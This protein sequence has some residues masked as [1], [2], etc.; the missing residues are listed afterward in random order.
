MADNV[1]TYDGQGHPRYFSFS[2]E[3]APAGAAAAAGVSGAPTAQE[4]ARNFLR[5]QASALQIPQEAV[6]GLDLR[7]AITP[8]VEEQAL[9][10]ESEK[11]LMDSTVVSFTQ[12]MFGLPIYQAGVSVTLQSPDNSVRAAS[13]TLHYDIAAQPPG[14]TLTGATMNAAAVGGYD[15]LVRS[16]LPAA[17]EMRINRTR[18]MVYRY[19]AAT[20]TYTHAPGDSESGFHTEPPTLPLPPLASSI[21]D[22]KHYVAVEALFALP[23]EGYPTLNWR[24]FIEPET[25]SVLYLRALTDGA[26]G[27]VFDRDPMT[28]TANAANLPSANSA[29]LNL[30]R[31]TITLVDLGPV[32]AGQQNLT[33]SFVF[34]T[35][36]TP[37]TPILPTQPAPFNFNY[38]SRT[39]DFAAVNAYYHCDRFF[40]MVR[41]LGFPI[42]TYFDG[43]AFPVPVDH[44]GLGDAVNAQCPGDNLGDGIGFVQFAL[45]DAG[46]VANPIGIAADWRVVLHELAGHGILWDH[47]NS[48]NFGFAHSAGDGIAAIA[49]DPGTALTGANRFI[50]FPWVNI[51]RRHDRPVNGWGWGGVN[52]V[53]GYSSEQ[54][55]ATSHFRFY[56]SIGGDSTSQ[57]RRQFASDTAIYLI[58]RAV[59]QLSPVS[60]P[61]AGLLGPQ[62]WEQELETADSF[63]WTRTSPAQ[64]HAGGAYR[65]VIRWAFEKQGLFR[66]A[67]QPATQEGKPPAVDVYIDDGRHGEYPFQPNHWSCTDIWNRLTVGDGGGVH[68]EPEVGQTNF[69]YVRIKNRGTQA[70]TNVVVK[71]FHALPGVGL[72]FPTDWVAMATPSLNAPNI[73]ANNSVG[74]IVGPF[75]WMPSQ[76]GHECMFFSVSAKGDAG[77]IDGHVVGPIPEWRLV[78]HDNN[79]GQRN[80]HPVNNKL[81]LVLWEKLPFWIRNRGRDP[82]QLGVEIKLPKWLEQLG[83]K[84]DV[85]QI[86]RERVT[87][88]P[89]SPPLKVAIA[90]TKGKPFDE[91][92][93]KQERDHDIVLTVLYDSAPAGGMTYRIT[94]GA[95]Q[96]GLAGSPR[97]AGSSRSASSAKPARSASSAKPARSAKSAK[98]SKSRRG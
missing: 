33:G 75:K 17:S 54:I 51:G 72:V 67:G 77:N 78:P 62:Q 58:L 82:V 56:R 83:W 12:T 7:A 5:A 4:A 95:G 11:H 88:K 80:V 45:A 41:D 9:R 22:G 53:G 86:T 52:D 6:Q 28:K 89:D 65:K 25:R 50:T 92:V 69:A 38:V 49:N 39:N 84:F 96:T 64:T 27:L 71:G 35:D 42:A 8:T 55:L 26:M 24:A 73:A 90:I 3:T 15:D 16:A 32:M 18:L 47:V 2:P 93:L 59:G 14:D 76:V 31:D 98:S 97:S 44:R 23:V 37:P 1:V 40:R 19:D 13:S 29:T 20:R 34:L 66:A 87:L 61:P 57:A 85:P 36:K 63:V 94:A 48:P 60:N 43:T 21:V 68:Q 70:A 30:L 81:D 46:D 10:F 91:A 74:V 79:I